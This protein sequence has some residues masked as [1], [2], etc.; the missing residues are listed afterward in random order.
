MI[1]LMQ[2]D[3]YFLWC[4]P[5]DGCGRLLL[6]GRTGEGATWY[7]AEMNERKNIL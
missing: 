2:N 7:L 4:C 5:P 6:Q 3:E 1:F